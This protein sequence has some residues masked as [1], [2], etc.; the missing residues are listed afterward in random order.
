MSGSHRPVQFRGRRAAVRGVPAFPV[1]LVRGH[2]RL[3]QHPVL[4][5]LHTASAMPHKPGVLFSVLRGQLHLELVRDSPSGLGATV[6]PVDREGVQVRVRADG[7]FGVGGFHAGI[8][9][10][11][12]QVVNR[13]AAEINLFILTIFH[14]TSFGICGIIQCL[15]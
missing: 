4:A 15:G 13:V 3:L 10:D 6:S 8:L 2:E 11:P 9:T 1:R 14:L 7:G 12:G 5:V